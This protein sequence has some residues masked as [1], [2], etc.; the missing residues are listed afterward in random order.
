MQQQN[1]PR[2][3]FCMRTRGVFFCPKLRQGGHSM[4]LPYTKPAL[5]IAE[6][7]A[8]LESHGMTIADHAAA[9]HNLQHISYYRLSAYWLA[10]ENSKVHLGPR[11][12]PDTS[13]E[14]VMAL[15]EFDRKL[16]LLVLDAVERVEVAIRGSWAYQMAML[17]GSHE[18]LDARHYADIAK[19]NDNCGKLDSE[20]RRSKDVFIKHYRAKYSEPVRPPI[21]MAAE[22]LSFGLLSQWYGALK[23][24]KLRQAIAAPFGLDEKIFVGFVHHLTVVR[25]ICAHHSRLWNRIIDVSFTLPKKQ[26][27]GLAVALNRE[28]SKRTYNTFSMLQFLLSKAEPNND[29]GNRL[30][31]LMATLPTG[32]ET[33]MGFP[34]DWKSIELW[35]GS[36]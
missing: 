12:K 24:P 32:R 4:K 21:W 34:S 20:A 33:A 6:Q 27:A 2:L 25:N 31:A 9:M 3:C 16:R 1:P 22:L 13:F 14:G 30:I 26:P 8:K 28:E 18:Y 23:E 5:S 7:I 17:G 19:Y 29:W 35:G 36:Q 10:F 15:Y 11:F